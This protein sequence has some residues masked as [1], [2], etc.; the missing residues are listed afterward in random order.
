M[1]KIVVVAITAVILASCAPKLT[2]K[3][4]TYG[5]LYTE[6][7][8]T[9]LA[10]PP[11]NRS[12]KVEAKELFYSSLAVPLTLKGYYVMPPL[13]SMEIMKEESVYDAELLLNNSMKRVGEAFGVDAV[14]FTIIHDWRKTTIASQITVSIEYILKS[15]KTD[16]VMFNRKGNIT[17]STSVNTGSAIGNLVGSMLATALTKEITVGRSC[18]YY[19]ISDIPSGKYDPNFDKDGDLP[20]HPKEFSVHLQNNY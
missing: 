5:Q 13:L 2:P 19:T 15:T 8:L 9:I 10:L 4:E 16:E 3:K 11:I 1:K 6:K 14:L 12:T 17:L 18:N 7:P 20:A